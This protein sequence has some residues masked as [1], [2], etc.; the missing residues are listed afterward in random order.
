[1]RRKDKEISEFSEIEL[2]LRRGE[3][4]R[5]ALCDNNMPY[6]VPLNYGYENGVLYF[7]SAKEGTKVD[8]IRK[9]NQA[10]FEVEVDAKIRKGGDVACQWSM[11]FKSVIGFGKI[12]EVKD[13]E[14]KKH[15]L[16]LIMNQYTGKRE[17]EYPDKM[18]ER[19]MILKL[20]V[21]KMTGKSSGY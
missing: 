7:H 10:C 17:W 21:D 13:V 18:V 5:V 15:A 19:V 3:V 6:I 12:V 1:M 11:D 14:E 9:N 16:S 20:K 4:C 8:I 2:L